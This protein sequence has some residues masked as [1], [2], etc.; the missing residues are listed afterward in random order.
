[1]VQGTGSWVG[2]SVIV[3]ALCRILRQDGWSVAP[4]KSQNMALNSFV[5]R[6]GKEM[7]R[8]Q[9]VQ[10]EAA[11]LEPDVDM[12]PILIKP[13]A[14]AKAQVVVMGKPYK[15]LAA[16]DY[17]RHTPELLA[18]AKESLARLRARYDIV[19][20]EGAGSPAEVNLHAHEIVNMRIAKLA[21]APVLLVGD[22]DKGGV[23]A[24]LVGTLALLDDDERE[25]VKGFII[26]KF[27]G[28]IAL[29]RPGLEFLEKR[30][31]RPVLGVVPYYHGIVIAEEDSVR[32]S[33][34]G[35]RFTVPLPLDV[36]TVP[37]LD[38]AVIHL[39]RISNSTD[40]EPLQQEPGVS[41]RY[42]P[43]YGELGHP[44]LII[45]PGSKST[46]ADLERLRERGLAEAI[47]RRAAEGT[48][49]IGVCGGFQ[50]LGK[51][52]R[53]PEGV[54]SGA[55]SV[56]GLGLL[57]VTTVFEEEK[58]TCQ[59]KARVAGDSGL[60]AGCGGQ[61]VVGYEIHMGRSNGAEARPA[62]HVVE[63]PDGLTDY[64]D[65]ATDASSKVVGTYLHGLFDNT[66][67]RQ[68]L[69]GNLRRRKGLGPD[70]TSVALGDVVADVPVRQGRGCAPGPTS[71]SAPTSRVPSKEEHYDALADLVR[72]SLDMERV[73]RIIGVKR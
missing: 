65:G 55:G 68:Q 34:V 60:L 59:V 71:P 40:F 16:G 37:L 52:I 73:Y 21:Q 47:V 32:Q 6:D 58:A 57:E 17:Y 67:F 51:E 11:G 5:T 12:N 4:F 63:R 29:L 66:A 1:M 20:I 72:G 18:V 30:T 28:D 10:A 39:P 45:L 36:C 43:M 31:G 64:P 25:L 70:A 53:D 2:K 35:A 14:D 38:I 23:F 49:V 54:E 27:R 15:T 33:Q 24:S 13:E 44:D 61:E 7:G 8:A 41:V 9:V 42:V 69:L 50:M 48:P 26:N 46:I 22:I 19:L 56:P 3:A 62:F